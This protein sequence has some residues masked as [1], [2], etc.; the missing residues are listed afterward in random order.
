[1]KEQEILSHR[2]KKQNVIQHSGVGRKPNPGKKQA[3]FIVKLL[4]PKEREEVF[5]VYRQKNR[6]S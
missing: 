3:P 4:K 2:C 5:E 6:L 1:L